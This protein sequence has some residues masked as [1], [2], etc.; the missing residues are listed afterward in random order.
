MSAH[1]THEVGRSSATSGRRWRS[2]SV[3]VE[4]DMGLVM[5]IADRVTVLDFGRVIA[6]GTPRRCSRSRGDPGVP[7]AG[8]DQEW[9]AR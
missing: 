6:D 3:L 2:P 4:H 5:D 7:R 9:E 8:D 1:E